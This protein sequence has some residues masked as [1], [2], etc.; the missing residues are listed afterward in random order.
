MV[1][2]A[3]E[4]ENLLKRNNYIISTKDPDFWNEEVFNKQFE[5]KKSNE[6]EILKIHFCHRKIDLLKTF[7]ANFCPPKTNLHY[8]THSQTRR[9][10]HMN[11]N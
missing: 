5:I 1:T 11:T 2:R 7:G 4:D 8:K 10:T 3:H 6:N 9:Y